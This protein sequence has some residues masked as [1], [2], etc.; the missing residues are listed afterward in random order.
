MARTRTSTSSPTTSST[1]GVNDENTRTRTSKT[2]DLKRQQTAGK[3]PPI[4]CLR[5]ENRIVL[6]NNEVSRTFTAPSQPIFFFLLHFLS[7]RTRQEKNRSHHHNFEI[8]VTPQG[9]NRRKL[10]MA[11]ARMSTSSPTT[12]STAGV[13]D[14]KQEQDS[15]SDIRNTSAEP[16]DFRIPL[17]ATKGITD[18]CL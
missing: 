15:R 7:H 10:L 17:S 14:N 2:H 9:S 13:N 3:S 16:P 8:S 4:V 6:I 18:S 1:A 11:G 5:K 12:S